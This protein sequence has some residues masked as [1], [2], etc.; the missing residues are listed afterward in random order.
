MQ[1]FFYI[2]GLIL[3]AL[4]IFGIVDLVVKAARKKKETPDQ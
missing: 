2:I 1:L 4:I 3:I